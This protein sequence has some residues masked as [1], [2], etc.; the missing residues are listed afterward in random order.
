MGGGIVVYVKSVATKL[1]QRGHKIFIFAPKSDKNFRMPKLHKNISVIQHRGMKMFFYPDFKLTSILTINDIMTFKKLKIDLVFFQSPFS[2]GLKGIL[3]SKIFK[4]PLIGVFHTRIDTPDYLSNVKIFSKNKKILKIARLYVYSYYNQSDLILSPSK[5]IKDEL[6]KNN[7]KR[8]V[9][10][11]NNFIDDSL[12]SDKDSNISIHPNSFVYLG[13]ISIEKNLPCLLKGFKIVLHK[14]PSSHFYFVGRGPYVD[15]LKHLILQNS[16]SKNVHIIGPIDN[17][18]VLGTNFLTKFKA[19]VTMSNS[20]VQPL[21]ILEAMFKGVP[22]IGPDSAG[23]RELIAN[24][25]LLVKK[26]S[27]QELS[28]AMIKILENEKLRL[29]LSKNSIIYSKNFTSK[30]IIYDLEKLFN[31]QLK[32]QPG[33][34]NIEIVS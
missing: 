33:E 24:N 17:S 9:V 2:I 32:R 11:I 23:V 21:S 28:K 1:A 10:V 4:K 6:L 16:L 20:E 3:L 15:K 26:N 5:D 8:P 25:G 7:I 18:V 14:R 19:F 31:K 13:R 27:P 30:K 29:E 34:L 12:L 22:I